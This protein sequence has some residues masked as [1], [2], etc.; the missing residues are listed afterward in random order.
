MYAAR[1]V[2]QVAGLQDGGEEANQIAVLRAMAGGLVRTN[3]T[4][5]WG[6]SCGGELLCVATCPSDPFSVM[7]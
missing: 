3:L 2:Q 6:G 5:W 1:K 7:F 4:I